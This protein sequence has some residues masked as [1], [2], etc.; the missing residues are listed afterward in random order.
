MCVRELF[1]DDGFGCWEEADVG[2][3]VAF[4]PVAFGPGGA[5]IGGG[6]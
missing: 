1:C 5:C 6:V 2:A 3:F 4:I